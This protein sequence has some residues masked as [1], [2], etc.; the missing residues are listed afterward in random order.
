[1]QIIS[2]ILKGRKLSANYAAGVRPVTS[3]IL[4]Q[5]FDILYSV[6][7]DLLDLFAGT[8]IIGLEA[9]SRGVS[10]VTAVEKNRQNCVI[11]E[12]F[13]KSTNI[14]DNI[15][16]KCTDATNIRLDRQYDIIFIDPPY[17]KSMINKS[18]DNLIKQ[19]ALKDSGILI[20]K[21]S[22]RELIKSQTNLELQ[23][24]EIHGDSVINFW[25]KI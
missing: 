1:M 8:G 24:T 22:K 21:S 6:E 5:I 19:N 18:L 11:L 4:R 3:R 14:S 20:T 25:N 7:G 9:I 13:I 2:G 12:D 16:V 23:R 15:I 17:E 10:H